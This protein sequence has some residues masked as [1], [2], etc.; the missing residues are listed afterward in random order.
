[1]EI[2]API[3]QYAPMADGRVKPKMAVKM[4]INQPMYLVVFW[5]FWLAGLAVSFSTFEVLF[6]LSHCGSFIE[7]N[8]RPTMMMYKT[9]A[10]HHPVVFLAHPGV[11]KLVK[12]LKMVSDK[13]K[14]KNE[15]VDSAALPRKA[16]HTP[17]NNGN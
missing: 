10:V 11:L 7:T 9:K 12:T 14:F 13:C 2:S 17:M 16:P 4:N 3:P 6:L 15:P 1:M 8:C 5:L